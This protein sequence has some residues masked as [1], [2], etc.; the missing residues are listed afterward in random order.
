LNN[1][2]VEVWRVKLWIR[3]LAASIQQK[4]GGNSLMDCDNPDGL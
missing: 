4:L 2:S 1:K 3:A